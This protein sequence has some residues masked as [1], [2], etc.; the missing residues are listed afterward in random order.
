MQNWA[1]ILDGHDI[2]LLYLNPNHIQPVFFGSTRIRNAHSDWAYS[3]S[4]IR[5]I[6]LIRAFHKCCNVEPEEIEKLSM[7][8]WV[9]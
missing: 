1:R 2:E 8:F 9:L 6:W 7:G 5:S 3:M 4:F